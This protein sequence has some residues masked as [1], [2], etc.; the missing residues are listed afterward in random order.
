MPRPVRLTHTRR[1]PPTE[2]RSGRRPRVVRS[3]IRI[4]RE[5]R[6][7]GSVLPETGFAPD[8]YVDYG[9]FLTPEGG[10]LIIYK[11]IDARWRY[12]IWRVFAWLSATGGGG[13]FLLYH[14]P[15]HSPWIKLV[16]F[17]AIGALNYFI[18]AR[19]VEI[20]R[21]VEIRPDCMILE[22]ADVFWA[23]MMENGLP[24]FTRD[25]DGNLL[26]VGAYGTRHVEY[27]TVRR[28]EDNDRMPEVF[29]GHLNEAM[30]R[31]WAMT[32]IYPPG[33]SAPG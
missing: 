3:N 13:W 30:T 31:L 6:T 17:L 11:D 21:R 26:L 9:R 12:T 15:V 28:F 7:R 20:Y 19:P 29:A 25:E 33:G 18:V 4:A 22:G 23:H 24:A 27:L 32:A 14:S 8:P 1:S 16:C 5:G 2:S 10:I